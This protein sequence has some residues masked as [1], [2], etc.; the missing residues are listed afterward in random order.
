MTSSRQD[1]L[2]LKSSKCR[3]SYPLELQTGAKD[4]FFLLSDLVLQTLLIEHMLFLDG[5]IL[6]SNSAMLAVRVAGLFFTYRSYWALAI[7][8]F[9]VSGIWASADG[10]NRLAVI[11]RARLYWKPCWL[12]LLAALKYMS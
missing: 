10:L 11:F 7:S 2:S 8:L 4:G 1:K 3:P 9:R 5:S 12:N 6:K